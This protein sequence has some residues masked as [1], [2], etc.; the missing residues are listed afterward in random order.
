MEFRMKAT[1]RAIRWGLARSKWWF[2]KPLMPPIAKPKVR[3][4]AAMDEVTVTR[5]GDCARIEYKEAGIAVTT[6]EIGPEIA[7]MSDSEIV[8]AHNQVLRNE[9]K[10]ATE[11]K[12]AVFEVPLGSAQIEYFAQCD[13]WVPRSCV[14]RC[15][16]QIAEDGEIIVKIDGRDLR[17]K[18][19]G[20]LLAV[21]GGWGMRIEF[22]PADEVHRRPVLQVREPR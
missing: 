14:L 5:D 2:Q 13:Q 18:Q 3:Y 22:V 9:A 8:E 4:I 11:Y 7:E 1:F 6:L 19:F 15:L 20:R 10:Q 21:H 17:L 16:I 12:H